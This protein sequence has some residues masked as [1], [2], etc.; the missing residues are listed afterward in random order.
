MHTC[1]LAEYFG[2]LVAAN[3]WVCDRLP[4]V[5]DRV[6]ADPNQAGEGTDMAH[7]SAIGGVYATESPQ[8][9]QILHSIFAKAGASWR[10]AEN[11]VDN[12]AKCAPIVRERGDTCATATRVAIALDTA[13]ITAFF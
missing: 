6:L 12:A 4:L 1:W 11:F 7:I 2:N 10:T 3:E 9:R 13:G 8:Q 5:F